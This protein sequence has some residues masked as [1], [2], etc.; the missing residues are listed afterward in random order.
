MAAECRPLL[1]VTSRPL[2][3]DGGHFDVSGHNV[4]A[5]ARLSAS[6]PLNIRPKDL[7]RAVEYSTVLFAGVC[8]RNVNFQ[9]KTT[10]FLILPLKWTANVTPDSPLTRDHITWGEVVETWEQPLQPLLYRD[11]DALQTQCEGR[12]V[13]GTPTS[14]RWVIHG[15]RDDLRASSLR[16]DGARYDSLDKGVRKSFGYASSASVKDF[17]QP[18]LEVEAEIHNPVTGI[19]SYLE[20]KSTRREIALPELLSVHSISAGTFR[21]A[22]LLP[23]FLPMLNAQLLGME[24]SNTLFS[25]RI[26]P[27]LARQAITPSQAR[28]VMCLQDYQRLEFLG[29]SVLKM[30][31]NCMLYVHYADADS[32]GNRP[33]E[34]ALVSAGNIIQQNATLAASAEKANIVPYIRSV[35]RSP[36]DWVPDGWLPQ[37]TGL[38]HQ[39]LGRKVRCRRGQC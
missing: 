22:S 2:P 1:L 33:N 6:F 9:P 16:P 26:I 5:F 36:A 38:K 31:V 37:P 19:I 14:M 21:T 24:M 4:P 15:V 28:P 30:A 35:Y 17:K 10:P 32:N 13:C 39:G 25:G 29:D 11:Y 20:A 7:E 3:F 12:V 8:R 18:L 34:G 27:H 23:I